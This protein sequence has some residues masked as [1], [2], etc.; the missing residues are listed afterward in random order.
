MVTPV[1]SGTQL[2]KGWGQLEGPPTTRA[3]VRNDA[4][5]EPGLEKGRTVYLAQVPFAE[6][7]A[8]APTRIKHGRSCIREEADP[9]PA[10]DCASSPL[11]GSGLTVRR[12]RRACNRSASHS[13]GAAIR[14]STP[15]AAATP[16][17]ARPARPLHARDDA[18]D[19]SAIAFS[20]LESRSTGI[21]RKP[22]LQ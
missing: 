7:H 17:R 20:R 12:S 19:A 15:F 16:C 1:A 14:A 6:L 10:L 18:P 3:R 2:G 9:N 11:G 21:T 22:S 8:P 4:M 5:V 13:W